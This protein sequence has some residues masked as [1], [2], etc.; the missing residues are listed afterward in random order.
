MPA[1]LRLLILVLSAA[2]M[3]RA[4]ASAQAPGGAASPHAPSDTHR[5]APGADTLRAAAP[6]PDTL[7]SA[8]AADT[9]ADTPA[10]P[11]SVPRVYRWETPQAGAEACPDAQESVHVCWRRHPLLANQDIG[12]PGTRAWTMSLTRM[13]PI[14]LHS[15][16]FSAW[17]SSPYLNGGLLPVQNFALRGPGGDAAALEEAW[18][19]V[20]PLDTPVTNLEWERGA[21]ALNLFNVGLR[22]MLTDRVYLGLEYYSV[23]ADSMSYDYQFNVHQPYLGGWGFLG[24]LYGPIDRDSASLVLE[25][26][27]HHINSA[28]FRPRVGFWLDTNQVLEAFFD[29]LD[30]NTALTWPRRPG[31][32]DTS[33]PA[34]SIQTLLP[35]TFGTYAGGLIHG[36][37]GDGWSTQAELSAASVEKSTVRTDTGSSLTGGGD[38]LD[39][40]DGTVLRLRGK[41][42]APGLPGRPWL[43]AEAASE[44]WTGRLSQGGAGTGGVDDGWLDRQ[45]LAMGLRP[46]LEPF[47]LEAEGGVTRSSRMD[48]RVFWLPRAG[49]LGGADLPL[50]FGVS[51]GV[52]YEERDPDW[53]TLFRHNPSLFLHPSPGLDPRADLGY[54]GQV[55]WM[56]PHVRLSAG[57]D[58]RRIADAWLPAVLPSPEACAEVAD[59]LYALAD[60]PCAGGGLPDSLALGL[61]NWDEERRDTWHYGAS[62][63]LGNWR[64]DLENR[65]LFNADARD[66]AVAAVLSNR[67]VPARVF[68]GALRWERALL[69]GRLDVYTGW[70]WEW[71]STR[72]AWVPNLQG[73][74]RLAKLDEYLVLDFEAGMRIKTFL[75]FFKGM[76]FN[77]DRYATEPGV[78]PPG[79]NFRFGVDWTL[80]N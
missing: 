5:A 41:A 25:G 56:S 59:S 50:G 64:L 26:Y 65:F 21:L 6:G 45:S 39:V 17:T 4:P 18:T 13:E 12:F 71:F 19:P 10:Y 31:A 72:Y 80:F 14:P 9:L 27:S 3:L 30:Q 34:D 66:G 8:R 53:E 47:R 49:L 70:T 23:T 42:A 22:R 68:K 58:F 61:R 79:V 33:G 44:S 11:D 7:R 24:R 63:L 62:L 55:T 2:A 1:L 36:Y 48:D 74:S 67:M 38:L 37:R 77:H 78:H 73:V 16:Y 43:E 52:S 75:L 20:V 51:A 35:S 76:N 69:D 60:A 40:W 57:V 29:R 54:R 15:P 46:D 28:H 32:T